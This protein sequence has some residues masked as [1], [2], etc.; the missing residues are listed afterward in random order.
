MS[1]QKAIGIE[2]AAGV[3]AL[4]TGGILLHLSRSSEQ[5]HTLK[6]GPTG[7]L[8]SGRVRDDSEGMAPLNPVAS[9]PGQPA[10]SLVPASPRMAADETLKSELLSHC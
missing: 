7:V 9:I 4:R 8:C 2:I 3:A 6:R 10:R 1:P 5:L